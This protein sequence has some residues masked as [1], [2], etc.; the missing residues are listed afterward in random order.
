LAA[1]GFF[2]DPLIRRAWLGTLW[3]GDAPS[4]L[5][6]VK[7]ITAAE[8]RIGLRLTTRSEER[9]RLIGGDWENSVP[10]MRRE[11]QLLKEADLLPELLDMT[12]DAPAPQEPI[13][14]EEET[15]DAPA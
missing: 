13:D 1:P 15:T 10:Q 14:N 9:A 6:P 5:D 11:E 2:A 7:E 4:T 12:P 8:K 3:Q